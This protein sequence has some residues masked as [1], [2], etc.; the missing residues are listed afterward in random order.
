[1]VGC[2]MRCRGTVVLMVMAT[3]FAM[4]SASA[5]IRI[6][7]REKRDSVNN[8]SSLASSPL[9]IE[10]GSRLSFGTIAEDGGVWQK[11]V[12]LVN[13]SDS[14]IVVRNVSS[15]CSCLQG[16]LTE[17]VVRAGARCTMTIKYNPKGHPGAVSQRLFVYTSLDEQRPTLVITLE[18]K[19]A[20]SANRSGDYP[21]SRGVL[22]LR[23]DGVELDG[24][25]RYRVACMNSGQKPLLLEADT[26]LSSQG[27]KAY[28]QPAR[29]EAGAEGDLIIECEEPA[30]EQSLRLYL[31][32]LTLA[33]RERMIVLQKKSKE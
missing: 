29:L 21:Y 7:P 15:S 17:R 27:V 26:L 13:E 4:E 14:P 30:E 9:R 1:M 22:L 24:S 12:T 18:G 32:G 16:E 8:V 3:L 2:S 31:K 6:I 23:R 5:Q 10:G 28:T 19:V 25:G 20:I 11:S 33:P